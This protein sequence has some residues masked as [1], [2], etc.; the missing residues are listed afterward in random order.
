[1]VREVRGSE[2]VWDES[3][4][5]SW[6]RKFVNNVQPRLNSSVLFPFFTNPW[7]VEVFLSAKGDC[8]LSALL[9][10]RC[11]YHGTQLAHGR[12]SVD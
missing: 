10:K 8:D 5:A 1:M 9:W 3:Q 6:K 4:K 2:T 12:P 11:K 7:W